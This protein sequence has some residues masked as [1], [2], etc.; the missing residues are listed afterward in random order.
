MTPSSTSAPPPTSWSPSD[1]ARRSRSGSSRAR[2]G[3]RCERS[4]PRPLASLRRS[5]EGELR[6]QS[7]RAISRHSLERSRARRR[8]PL[9][10]RRLREKPPTTMDEVVARYV[11]LLSA[12]LEEQAAE[13]QLCRAGLGVA[14]T[15]ASSD[16]G[17][18]PQSRPMSRDS[19]SSRPGAP[20]LHRAEQGRQTARGEDLRQGRPRHG[21]ERCADAGR[22]A[23]LHPGQPGTARQGGPPA[24]PQGPVRAR[25]Q[26]VPERERPAGAGP[27][28]RRSRPTRSPPACSSTASGSG[29]SARGWSPPPATSACGATRRRIPSCST[30]WPLVSWTNGWSIKA[31]HRRIMLSSTYQQQSDAAARL[32]GTRPAEPPALA[33]QPPAARLRVDARLAPGRRRARSTRP[34]AGRRSSLTEP[35][36]PAAA[37]RL[38]LHRP[39]EPRRRL[40][41]LRLRRARRHQPQAVRH[42][43]APAGPLPHEQPVRP[44]AGQSAGGG[45]RASR[46]EPVRRSADR[47]RQRLS[48]RPGP[49]A[50]TPASWPSAP[51][52]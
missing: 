13:P 8:H 20:A 39:P 5:A 22:P 38:R 30:T 14:P 3:G 33:V 16:R 48:P 9:L 19:C 40:P 35:P 32:P 25:S 31:L 41:D 23:R 51:S 43:G 7:R 17:D 52:S 6:R 29:T 42:H 10:A 45:P 1:S 47:V 36:F 18:S 50:P 4:R 11:E 15:R 49:I 24:V 2:F 12:A 21:H 46:G 26:A 27:G 37:D 28:H 34:R 44:G